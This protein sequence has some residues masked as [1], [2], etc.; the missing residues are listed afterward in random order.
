MLDV[1]KLI[2]NT[3]ENKSANAAT[4]WENYVFSSKNL[5]FFL[6]TLRELCR[7]QQMINQNQQSWNFFSP[8][9]NPSKSVSQSNSTISEELFGLA[10]VENIKKNLCVS[11]SGSWNSLY[12]YFFMS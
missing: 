9:V 7:A 1:L 5:F 10:S 8:K 6:K 4:D 11:L 2:R 3:K 12:A